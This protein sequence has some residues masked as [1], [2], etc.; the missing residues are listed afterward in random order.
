MAEPEPISYWF[1]SDL[2]QIEPG[3]DEETNPRMYGKE[4][5]T[6]VR[7]KL[8]DA[9]YSPEDVISEDYGWLVLC[10]RD[11]YTLGVVCVSFK[12]YETAQPGNLPPYDEVKWCCGILAEVPFFKRLFGKVDSTEGVQKL[13]SQLRS[14]F[15]A[16]P[17]IALI[18]AP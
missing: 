13:D 14:A 11:P 1:T 9:G 18:D 6:W 7:Q 10:S 2:F 17:R 8:I 5:A 12:D 3:E 4:L 16:E 15:E